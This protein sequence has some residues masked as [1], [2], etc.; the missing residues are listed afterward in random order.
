M[1]VTFAQIIQFT[2]RM[3]KILTFS[4]VALLSMSASYAEIPKGMAEVVLESNDVS[5]FG[6]IGFQWILDSSHSTYDQVF[7]SGSWMYFGDYSGFDYFV[8]EGAEAKYPTDYKVVDGI[9]SAYVPAG[10]YDWMVIQ[11]D[12]DGLLFATGEMSRVDDFTLL[13]GK[14]YRMT[15]TEETG[16]SGWGY[17]ATLHVATDLSV[18]AV[19]VPSASIDLTSSENIGMTIF[20]NGSENM[21][22][23]TLSYTINGGEPITETFD[24]TL[25]AGETAEY[26]FKTTADLSDKGTYIISVSINAA[27]DMIASNNTM[28]AKTRNLTPLDPPYH[29]DFS[30]ISEEAFPEEWFIINNSQEAGW[31][32]SAWK[33]NKDGNMGVAYCQSGYMEDGNDWMISQPISLSAGKAHVI[34]SA[35]S[36]NEERPEFLEVYIG[37]S[38]DTSKMDC[39]A[40]Y[41]LTS[42]EWSDKAINFDAPENGIY[43]VAFRGVSPTTS[44]SFYIG[45]VTIDAGEFIGSPFMKMERLLVPY[46]N[47]DLSAKS[48]L[49]MRL[50]NKGTGAMASYSMTVVVNEEKTVT[51]FNSPIMPDETVDVYMD[52]TYDLSNIGKYNIQIS[53]S[54]GGE[55]NIC[56]NVTVECFEPLTEF[57]VTTNFIQGI[58]TDNW[59]EMTQGAWEFE[60][61]FEVFSSV[62]PGKENGLLSR[63]IHFSNPVR[64]KLSYMSPGWDYGVLA[65]YMGLASDDPATY[66]KVFYD[67]EVY[68]EAK[69]VEFTVPIEASGNY[70]FIIADEAPSDSRNRLRLNQ[71]EITEVNP[72]DIC[73]TS[74]DGYLAP[75]TPAKAVVG[76]H[77]YKVNVLNRGSQKMTGI[78]AIAML[79]GEFTSESVNEIELAS[80]E[81]GVL[82][83]NVTIPDKI[84]GDKF[85]LSFSINGNQKDAFETDNIKK[86]PMINVT[87]STFAHE[88]LTDLTYGT[89]NNGMPLSVGYVYSLPQTADATSMTVGLALA[90]D[91][92]IPNVTSDIAFSIYKL[93]ADGTIERRLWTE[94][95]TR[96]IGGLIEVDFQ[97]MRLEPGNYFFE[98]SQLSNYNMGIAH[99]IDNVA[100]CYMHEDDMLVPVPAYPVC[101]RANFDA[102]AKVYVKDASVTAFTSPEYAEGLYSDGMTI[103]AIARNSGYEPAD[104]KVELSLDGVKVGEQEVAL[105]SYDEA[106]VVFEGVDLSNPGLHNL[107]AT[108]ILAGDENI[109]NDA[110]DFSINSHAEANPYLMDFENCFDFDAAGDPWNPR[111][112]TIDR[113]GV[114]TDLFWRYQHPYRGEP[115]GFIAFNIKMTIPSMEEVPLQGFYPHSGERFGVAF[116]IDPWAEGAEGIEASDVWIISPK[117]QLGDNSEFELYVKTRM[118]EG[119]FS[120]LEP[121]RI[122]ISETDDDPESFTVLGDEE[123][124]AAVEDWEKISIDLSDYDG[125][126]VHVAL[127]YI[128]KPRANTC[129]MIDD[130]YVKTDISSS[131]GSVKQE[132]TVKVDGNDIIAPKGSIVYTLDGMSTRMKS[133]PAGIYIV[134][135]PSTTVKVMIP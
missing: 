87:E 84:P 86:L 108:A 99:D 80:G 124:L 121:Y 133:L 83:M 95:R 12:I 54:D 129:L 65:I 64:F 39:V 62:F 31:N 131:V 125:K 127:Q 111:W 8:P 32:Y 115:V 102:D 85:E 109:D 106:E 101:I 53:L 15:V 112:T 89:G 128:G 97:D 25:S 116:H 100:T 16:D 19:S 77:N 74:V 34:F 70:S 21:S 29:I 18:T 123:R 73:L 47:C 50:T 51:E 119:S 9:A 132:D 81:S 120:E 4:L 103:K 37:R 107:T 79:D 40:K 49:G 52:D 126:K 72:Y 82:E 114:G 91:E 96:G 14:S 28:E 23:F 22:D 93:K 42:S 43:Y 24:G 17:Y 11:P 41:T 46:S 26:I 55:T 33:M 1:I 69:E 38:L 63:G 61:M 122:L 35:A 27:G 67:N 13:E 3:R 76:S 20:N 98:V 2:K 105:I 48:R 44:Y 68:S 92:D 88:N 30:E 134:K 130:L 117:L 118:L 5:G 57:P 135:T 90:E 71:V 60:P 36:A 7:F 59:Q 56:E 113:N 10:T 58:N 78:K 6:S 75:Y 110:I 104:F 94:K 45:D 66:E